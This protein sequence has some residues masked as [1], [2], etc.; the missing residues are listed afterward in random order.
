MRDWRTLYTAALAETDITALA[1]LVYKTEEAITLS[2]QEFVRTSPG[3]AELSELRAAANQLLRVKVQ[4]LGWP[5]PCIG[6]SSH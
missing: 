5:D 1:D 6:K 4:R 2:L 3:S